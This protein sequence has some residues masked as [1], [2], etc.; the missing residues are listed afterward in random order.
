M[1]I[2]EPNAHK[3]AAKDERW[4]EAMREKIQAMKIND[5]WDIVRRPVDKNVVGSKWVYK[6]KYKS[7]GT[8]ERFKARLV[9]IG[10]IQQHG[11]ETFNPMVKIVINV[12]E[13]QRT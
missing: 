4:V 2:K 7:D 11:L 12:V 1:K 8:I 13:A 9:A 6:I 5:A 3:G 10:F